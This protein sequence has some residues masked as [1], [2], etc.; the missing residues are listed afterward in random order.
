MKSQL[1]SEEAQ[2]LTNGQF[3]ITGVQLETFQV[4]GAR[5]LTILTPGCTYD[6]NLKNISSSNSLHVATAD[7]KFAIQGV[8][9]YWQETNSAFIIS[10]AVKTRID[11]AM[12]AEKDRARESLGTT[13][14]EPLE[15]N[16][17]TFSYS[18]DS[19]LGRYSGDVSVTSSNLLLQSGVL[20]FLMPFEERQMREIT[21]ENDVRVRYDGM[22]ANGQKATY[23]ILDGIARVTGRPT[24][25][26]PDQEGSA[27]QVTIHRAESMIEAS[28]HANLTMAGKAVANSPFNAPA[29]TGETPG[30]SAGTNMS[31]V[32]DAGSYRFWTNKA[33]FTERVMVKDY[34]GKNLR[35]ALQGDS[36]FASFNS[37]DSFR[38]LAAKGHVIIDQYQE[39]SNQILAQFTADQAAFSAT[40][41]VLELTGSPAW[42][43]GER[44]GSGDVIRMDATA[45]ELAVLGAARMDLPA[46]ELASRALPDGQT[47]PQTATNTIASISSDNYRLNADGAVFSGNVVIRHP[48]VEWQCDTVSVAFP[49]EGGRVDRMLAEGKVRFDLRSQAGQKLTGTCERALYRTQITSTSTNDF[50]ELTG[51]PVLTS[52]NGTFRGDL[53]VLDVTNQKLVAPQNYRIEPTGLGAS[54]NVL[55]LPGNKLFR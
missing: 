33:E 53:L 50:I 9:F 3:L 40:N 19:G 18:A 24:W 30:K 6:A 49:K 35:S 32:I 11:P 55:R 54:T 41:N 20:T 37:R 26:T 21:A 48:Q 46:A 42:R 44:S 1:R 8:G 36:L 12:I 17:Q 28:G 52:T 47:N 45:R 38:D 10:N 39:G 2:P 7:G 22:T 16:S 43:A 5:E 13:P 4:T 29:S 27:D 14:R 15:I 23:S 25:K 31:I 34:A 51:N